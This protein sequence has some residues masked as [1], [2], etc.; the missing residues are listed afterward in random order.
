MMRPLLLAAALLLSL[1]AALASAGDELD[2]GK[3]DCDDF[4]TLIQELETDEGAGILLWLDGYL[5][6]IT[7]DTVLDPTGMEKNSMRLVKYC[8]KNGS[9]KLLDATRRVGTTSSSK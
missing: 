6:G 1:H 9:V 2:F 8:L 7:G 3:L 5:S 4:T